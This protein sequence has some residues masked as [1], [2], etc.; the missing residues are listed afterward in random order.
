MRTPDEVALVNDLRVRGMT[1]AEIARY[2]GIPY[3]TVARW[4]SGT[5]P[6]FEARRRGRSGKNGYACPICANCHEALP[7]AHYVYLL[8]LYL[9]DGCVYRGPKGV[10]RLGIFCDDKYPKLAELCQDAMAAVLPTK[11]G[12][13]RK[14]GC[15]EIRRTRSIG[16]ACSRS[17]VQG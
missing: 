8:G 2:T 13:V 7:Q 11:V 12:R 6:D 15:T 4:V 16:R 1:N 3:R 10:Y 17:T 14:R 5:V 9:G